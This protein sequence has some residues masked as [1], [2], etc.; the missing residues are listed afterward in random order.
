MLLTRYGTREW[1]IITLA[2]AVPAAAG[3]YFGWWW[4]AIAALIVWAALASFFRDPLFRRPA[5]G[6]ARDFVSP[7]DGLVSAVL[8]VPDQI[9]LNGLNKRDRGQTFENPPESCRVTRQS[10]TNQTKTRV[11]NQGP[12]LKHSG[13]DILP[14]QQT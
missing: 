12:G 10:P 14:P 5:T 13:L 1:M 9:G 6:D 3:V 2:A 11:D 7:A 8:E 4:L